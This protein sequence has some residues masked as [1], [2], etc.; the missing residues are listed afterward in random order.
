MDGNKM[1]EKDI[2]IIGGG[3]A[4][5]A[6]ATECVGNDLEV[7]L[8]ERNET[9]GGIL[10]QCIHN[11]FGLH[12]FKEELTGPEYAERFIE[13]VYN[14]DI[15]IMLRTMVTHVSDEKIVTA[16]NKEGVHHIK[17]KS[18]I[19][20]MGC[21]E[22]TGGAINLM[23]YRP[24]GVYMAGSAQKLI[25][26]QNRKVGTK[27]IIYGSGD[28]GLIMARRLTFE[29]I[30][31][32]AVVEINKE[33]SGLKRNIAQCLNDFNIP[34]LLHHRIKKVYGK[35]RVEGL[36]IENMDTG[37]V[38]FYEC[39][40]VL[41]SVGLIPENDIVSS[42]VEMSALTR[43]P[44]VNNNRE[45]TLEGVFSC[46]NVL[47]VHDIVDFVS[48][49]ARIAGRSA[50]EYVL[51]KLKRSSSVQ[52]KTNEN[53]LYA[54]PQRLIKNESVDLYFR[55][56]KSMKDALLKVSDEDGLIIQKKFMSIVP[57]EMEKIPVRVKDKDI[58]M[59][60]V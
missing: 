28:I 7:L 6:A 40:T 55:S 10:N 50:K 1:I 4:G 18:V 20:A 43:G 2:V 17:A 13:S 21:R 60:L 53:V 32:K 25:N 56:R 45:T 47:H 12:E 23:G 22:R 15:D 9:L 24:A 36:D 26:I 19:Y 44:V 29:G 27:A 34:L 31:V 58:F 54:L 35:D 49:E 51:G 48:E 37:E 46:G 16:I 41:L 42:G 3:P 39:D 11:G 5:L 38:T 59:E 52:V 57:S 8:I 14:L 33:S 30:D